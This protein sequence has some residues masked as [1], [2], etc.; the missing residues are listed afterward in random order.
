MWTTCASLVAMPKP[1]APQRTVPMTA[2]AARWYTG[3][4]MCSNRN[5]GSRNWSR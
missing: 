5:E 1:P 3:A 2:I 4:A